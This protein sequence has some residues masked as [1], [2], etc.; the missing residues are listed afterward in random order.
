M[1]SITLTLAMQ[2]FTPNP[3]G[4]YILSTEQYKSSVNTYLGAVRAVPRV[5]L[6]QRQEDG[7]EELQQQ[8][9]GKGVRSKQTSGSHPAHWRSSVFGVD[10]Y[11]HR[12][13][14]PFVEPI[15]HNLLLQPL[16]NPH[17]SVVVCSVSSS[18]RTAERPLP[19]PD[20]NMPVRHTLMWNRFTLR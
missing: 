18:S 4:A 5:E 19:T 6:G 7:G 11:G 3:G 9:G 13:S 10:R 17:T 12:P 15:L 16:D 8:Q 14:H 1:H 20:M 2:R